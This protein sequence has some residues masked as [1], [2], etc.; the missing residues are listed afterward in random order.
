MLQRSTEPES[1]QQENISSTSMPIEAVLRTEKATNN[2][3]T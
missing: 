3:R 1:I 2:L